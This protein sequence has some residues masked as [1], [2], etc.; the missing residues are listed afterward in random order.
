[1]DRARGHRKFLYDLT[2]KWT[3]LGL[4]L[5]LF[6]ICTALLTVSGRLSRSEV[7][8]FCVTAGLLIAFFATCHL[9]LYCTR[10]KD[11]VDLEKNQGDSSTTSSSTRPGESASASKTPK[12][13]AGV[14][15]Q[16]NLDKNGEQASHGGTNHNQPPRTRPNANFQAQV[17]EA[18]DEEPIRPPLRVVNGVHRD[19]LSP[20]HLQSHI[21]RVHSHGSAAP[22]P[23]S[24]R[25]QQA[26]HFGGGRRQREY[27]PY[28]RP[29]PK[30]PAQHPRV[31]EDRDPLG[32][33]SSLHTSG[34]TPERAMDSVHRTMDREP[35]SNFRDRPPSQQRLRHDQ[36]SASHQGR[37]HAL[38]TV[39]PG[40]RLE[41]QLFLASASSPDN[42][43]RLSTRLGEVTNQ[44]GPQNRPVEL[45]AD[46]VRGYFVLLQ[47]PDFMELLSRQHLDF[48]PRLVHT[49]REGDIDMEESIT[50]RNGT[51]V[52]VLDNPERKAVA[53]QDLPVAVER[54]RSQRVQVHNSPAGSWRRSADSGY[55]SVDRLRRSISTPQLH[56]E[57]RGSVTSSSMS[58]SSRSSGV[59]TRRSSFY[60]D[61]E[62]G[63]FIAVLR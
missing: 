14:H 7:I 24:T 52:V 43:A 27:K 23:L 46:D 42:L 58:G 6:I 40:H 45:S 20:D 9:A 59:L 17:E 48:K 49:N 25:T 2:Y 26:G 41:R 3:P 47:E 33:L 53:I 62:R 39:P 50:R 61:G 63:D 4:V 36:P 11:Q 34:I 29:D 18:P 1:M 12:P 13:S 21:H 44:V 22:E 31:R 16:L 54:V 57:G 60:S 19:T 38:S 37:F 30:T 28:R 32:E 55:Y 51:G 15:G 8:G 10:I 5:L 56:S 35:W